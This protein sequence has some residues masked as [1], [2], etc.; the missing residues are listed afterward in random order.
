ML[1]LKRRFTE[2]CTEGFNSSS[3][4]FIYSKKA[5]Y[6]LTFFQYYKKK[7]E[8]GD[9]HGLNIGSVQD[10]VWVVPAAHAAAVLPPSVSTAA[11]AS[12]TSARES[13]VLIPVALSVVVAGILGT[14]PM[15]WSYCFSPCFGRL[16]GRCRPAVVR[17]RDL[18]PSSSR[19]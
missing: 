4:S 11:A 12:R 10:S 14:V 3:S 15:H 17:R 13:V 8:L 18:A 19:F 2:H 5:W 6:F 9:Q 1:P 16:V 7:I